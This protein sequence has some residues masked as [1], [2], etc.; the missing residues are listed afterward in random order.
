MRKGSH[1]VGHKT[2]GYRHR[3]S[4]AWP[5]VVRLPGFPDAQM[6]TP[7]LDPD[8]MDVAPTAARLTDYDELHIVTYIRLLQADNE[9]ANWEDVARI[10][11]HIDPIR[12]PDRA[13]RALQSHLERAKWMTEQGRL[14][15]N[16]W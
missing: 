13:R 7:C 10:V 12:E 6:K 2:T 3:I 16:N 8:V 15:R 5:A 9:G 4:V 14:L 11:L 1:F